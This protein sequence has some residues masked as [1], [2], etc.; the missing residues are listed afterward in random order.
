MTLVASSGILTDPV[1]L[2]LIGAGQ[3]GTQIYGA[4]ALRHP[5]EVRFVAAA[6]PDLGRLGTFGERHAISADRLYPSW[7]SLLDAGPDVDGIVVATQDQVHFEPTIQAV[8]QGLPVLLEKPVSNTLGEVVALSALGPMADVTVAHG[9]RYSPLFDRIRAIL[10]SGDIGDLIGIDLIENIGYWHFAHSY[11]RGNWRRESSSSPMILSKSCHDLDILRWLAGARPSSV[12]SVGG[13]HHFRP[14]RALPGAPDRCLD[15]CP[16]STT[17]AYFAPDLYLSVPEGHW[18]RSVVG[19][20][21]DDEVIEQLRVG[22]YGRC[23]Y[24]ADNDA[25]DHQVVSIAFENGVVATLTISAFTA[26][27]TRTITVMGSRGEMRGRLD[28]GEVEVNRFAGAGRTSDTVEHLSADGSH[29]IGDDRMIGSFVTRLAERRIGV[30][31]GSP[32]SLPVSLDS[33]LM[34]FAAERSRR[35]G[36]PVDPRTLVVAGSG[37]DPS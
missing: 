29:G 27:I 9:L 12:H 24:H 22:P 5:D 30:V 17:C 10:D 33:H 35:S 18:P 36:L 13:L 23:V 11:V 16:H 28:S 8:K 1:R 19:P 2:A 25:P 32:T 20:G 7:Q 21:S 6:D 26:R 37:A 14:E 15:G 31:T 3:R 34:A 4:Y